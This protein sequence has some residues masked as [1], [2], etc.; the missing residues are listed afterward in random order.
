MKWSISSSKTF[1]Q[2][3]KKWYLTTFFANSRS[4][5]P[6]RVEAYLL[7]HLTN[8]YAWR[9]R[10][11]DQVITTFIVPRLNKGDQLEKSEVLSFA[12]RLMESQLDFAKARMYRD[13]TNKVT[14]Y[15]YCALLELENDCS[16]DE[17]SIDKINNE[18]EESLVNLLNSRLFTK[19]VEKGLYFVAQRTL[20]FN[21]SNMTI[22]CTPD[23]IVF[24][25][26]NHQ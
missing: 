25:V 2:C 3:P 14:A 9:G 1:F 11:V 16:L 18:I 8:M 17:K 4:D 24:L 20:Q 12:K 10:L 19:L 26:I 5:N 15:N 22:K 23:L 13:L 21:F 7:K 6:Q